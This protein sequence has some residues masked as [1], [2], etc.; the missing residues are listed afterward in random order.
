[1]ASTQSNIMSFEFNCPFLFEGVN[2]KRW[3]QNMLFFLTIKKDVAH[4]CSSE[5][6]IALKKNSTKDKPRRLLIGKKEFFG[7]KLHLKWFDW[8]I[9]WYDENSEISLW[10]LVK[11]IRHQGGSIKEICCQSLTKVSNDEWQGGGPITLTAEDSPQKNWQRYVPWQIIPNFCYY[12]Q[13]ASSMERF[14]EYIKT[15]NQGIFLEDSDNLIKDWGGSLKVG[16]EGESKLCTKEAH[17]ICYETW[18][19]VEGKQEEMPKSRIQQ[20][21]EL[22]ETEIL[23]GRIVQFLCYNCNK[24]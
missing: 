5:K 14:Q 15:Q 2:F 10:C 3:K 9:V 4:A 12:W 22:E 19:K 16:P 11:K 13:V 17:P 18:T 8:W 6:P 23:F 24:S 1:M 7:H 20:P 21:T